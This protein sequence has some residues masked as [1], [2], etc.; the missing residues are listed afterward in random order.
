MDDDKI[1]RTIEITLRNEAQFYSHLQAIQKVQKE[2]EKCISV[3]ERASVNL[4]NALTKTNETV[5][6]LSKKIGNLA[7]AQKKTDE[8]LN[9]VIIKA[10]KFFSNRNGNSEN[11][12]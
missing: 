6:K 3:L 10:E 9:A 11:K 7:D 2:S 5:E 4:F 1:E 12:R 8:R